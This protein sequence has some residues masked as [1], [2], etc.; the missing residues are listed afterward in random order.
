VQSGFFGDGTKQFDLDVFQVPLNFR[1][2]FFRKNRWRIYALA[3]VSLHVTTQSNYYLA[4]PDDFVTN[5]Y[6]P[7]PIPAGQTNP[8]ST[9]PTVRSKFDNFTKGWVEGGAFN[10][11]SYLS[12]NVGIGAEYF[13]TDYWSLYAQ[14][15]YGHS[16]IYLYD[17]LGPYFDRIHTNSL[18]FG[19]KVRLK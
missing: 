6:R 2:N 8:R 9:T 4:N 7:L 3:G 5:N 14:P 15:T 17:G 10:K 11:N 16:L 1:Y 19:I 12:G 18:T 13:I